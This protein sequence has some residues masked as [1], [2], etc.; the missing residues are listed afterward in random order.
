ME[1][2]H[3]SRLFLRSVCIFAYATWM[4]E[5]INH[6][7][8]HLGPVELTEYMY[9]HHPPRLP[10]ITVAPS[11]N[12]TPVPSMPASPAKRPR[13][14]PLPRSPRRHTPMQTHSR[15]PSQ[16][17]SR[18]GSV[19]LPSRASSQPQSR[20]QLRTTSPS[21]DYSQIGRAHV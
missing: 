6:F 17:P 5:M 7:G 8:H 19:W 20:T 16:V 11:I 18:E 10:G 2:L 15:T 12:A 4:M 13:A 14:S 3:G 21:H 9:A 1:I